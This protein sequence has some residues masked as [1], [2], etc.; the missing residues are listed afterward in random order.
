MPTA[1]LPETVGKVADASRAEHEVALDAAAA[2]GPAPRQRTLETLTRMAEPKRL[3]APPRPAP[4]S[5]P[6]AVDRERYQA[7]DANPVHQVA[8]APVSTFSI[9]V[10][11]GS[12]SNLRR[13][14][15]Q[16]RLPPA[17]AVRVEECINYFPYDDA[18]PTGRTPFAVHTELA[19]AP[20]NAERLLLRVALKGQD[21][22]KQ[23]L[24]PANLVFLVDVSGSMQSANKLP[25]LKS[26]LKLL[27]Q[28][29]RAQDRIALVTYAG[30]AGVA[31]PSTAGSDK[32][33][34]LAAIDALQAGGST[35]GASGIELAYQTAQAGFVQG[36]INRILLATD[37]DFNVGQ[38]NFEQLKA[39]VE[40][41]RTTG[42]QLTTL[43]FGTGNTN[44]QLMEQMADAGN[45]AYAYIDTLMEGHKVL[46][47]EMSS[48]LATIAKDV[49]IQ[50]EF[51][52]A[53]V[54]EYRLIGYE[55]RLLRREDFNNDKVDAGEI[56]A[57]HSVTALYELTPAGQRGLIDPLRYGSDPRPGAATVA[58]SAELAHVR[59][60]Y[61]QPHGNTSE[62]VEH[63][64]RRDAERA[65]TAA[66]DSFRFATAIAGFGQILRGGTYTGQWSIADARALAGGALGADRFGYRGEALRL[67]DLAAA[68]SPQPP[69]ATA[70][71]E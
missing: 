7:I 37:G 41:L 59:L 50:V 43:G 58:R 62:L 55:N 67:M 14:L 28:Q 39:R 6:P 13:F 3:P 30:A 61:K 12:W 64:V 16:G 9:D 44:E 27:V 17:N 21:M 25:L 71:L 31:L 11:T 40:Q 8:T 63:P 69:Q 5:P 65:L 57:G 10:D 35:A 45:G 19:P 56:G 29:L 51:N 15:N 33:A 20:W 48:T 54:S 23:T 47:N 34:I 46:V 66:S 2:S 52:P 38:T 4:L 60:R 49:K 26:A 70:P 32:A 36:G 53:A 24:P 68:L 22:A 42:V 1:T 18:P